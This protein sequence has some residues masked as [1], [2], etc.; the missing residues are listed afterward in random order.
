MP[1]LQD[2]SPDTMQVPSA[3]AFVI[4]MKQTI[5]LAK[6]CLWA[7]QDRMRLYENKSRRDV[8]YHEGDLVLLSTANLRAQGA[9]KKLIPKWIG[10]FEVKDII[11]KAAVRLHLS[12]GHERIH[13]VF[14]VSLVKPYKP[15]DGQQAVQVQPLPWLIDDEGVPQYEVSHIDDHTA[16]PVVQGKG[17]HKHKSPDVHHITAYRVWWK[18]YD[19]YTWEPAENLVTCAE[20]VEAYRRQHGLVPPAYIP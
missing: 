9:S 12:V 5:Q 10:P 4:N 18:G 7:A 14:H 20:L 6:Q 17:K 1:G 3:G 8:T 19:K 15:R 16:K 13:N 2:I 11:G